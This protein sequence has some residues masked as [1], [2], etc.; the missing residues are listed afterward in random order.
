MSRFH[1][2]L[3][4]QHLKRSR[5]KRIKIPDWLDVRG[6]GREISSGLRAFCK[7]ILWKI[8]WFQKISIPPHGW[9]LEIPRGGGGGNGSKFSRGAHVKN[10]P[11]VINDVKIVRDKHLRVS[12]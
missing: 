6:H 11:G 8:V 10:L 2:L 3:M 9:S 4:L 5:R 12:L 7:E 1:K